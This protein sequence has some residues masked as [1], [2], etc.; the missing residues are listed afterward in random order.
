MLNLHRCFAPSYDE[1]TKSFLE[2]LNLSEADRKKLEEARTKARRA[3]RKAIATATAEFSGEEKPVM[4]A[5]YTQ[6][7]CS[8]KTVNRPTHVPPQ[9]VDM[10]DGTYL[11]MSFASGAKPKRMASWFFQVADAALRQLVKEEGW[12]GYVE[13]PTCCRIII[14]DES[15]LDIPLYAIR[16]ERYVQ[17]FRESLVRKA[18]AQESADFSEEEA[19]I[20]WASLAEDDVLLA[21]R[22]GTWEASDPMQ[23]T[24]WVDGS[25][26]LSGEQL[27]RVWRYIK[28]WRDQQYKT[29]GPSSILLMV[30]VASKFVAI[31]GRDDLV[32]EQVARTLER[33]ILGPIPAPWNVSIDLNKLSSTERQQA[34]SRAKQLA[35]DLAESFEGTKEDIDDVL[36]CLS[37]QFGRHFPLDEQLV[38]VENARTHV[39]SYPPAKQVAPAFLGNN[40]SA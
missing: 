35:K 5:F 38:S 21:K 15:H 10:D 24:R 27:R 26:G 16:D 40:K 9:Q 29:G 28:G 2:Q 23:V 12:A 30:I 39:E 25:I 31:K 1:K 8:Y 14:D 4:P 34:S 22:D 18:L 6:G 17:L 13:K 37:A 20:D 32:I 33:A 7:S 36:E 11:P 3:L 19:D